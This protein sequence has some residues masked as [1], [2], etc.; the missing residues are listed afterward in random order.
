MEPARIKLEPL[1]LACVLHFTATVTNHYQRGG[2]KGT[3]LFLPF[4][5]PEVQN[6]CCRSEIEM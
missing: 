2:F 1:L 6:V 3:H 5:R 4:W